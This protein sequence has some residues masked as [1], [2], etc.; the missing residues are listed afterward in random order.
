MND[1]YKE[2]LKQY[3]EKRAIIGSGSYGNVVKTCINDTCYAVK[4]IAFTDIPS[5]AFISEI[6]IMS[7]IDHPNVLKYINYGYSISKGKSFIVLPLADRSLWGVKPEQLKTIL[8]QLS[9]GI[10]HLHTNNIIHGDIK[11]ANC[12]IFSGHEIPIIKVCDYGITTVSYCNNKVYI[13]DGYGMYYYTAPYRPPENILQTS[14][15]DKNSDIWALACTFYEIATGNM[16]ITI[17][18]KDITITDVV[19]SL[20]KIDINDWPDVINLPLY[21]RYKGYFSASNIGKNKLDTIQNEDLKDLLQKMLVYNPNKR[22]NIYQILNHKY[23]SDVVLPDDI[24]T[25]SSDINIQ[26]ISCIDLLNRYIINTAN[27][28]DIKLRSSIFNW[29][30]EVCSARRIPVDQAYDKSLRSLTLFDHYM[31][32]DPDANGKLYAMTSLWCVL[33]RSL[34]SNIYMDIDDDLLGDLSKSFPSIF[35]IDDYFSKEIIIKSILNVLKSV[36]FNMIYTTLRDYMSEHTL[37]PSIVSSVYLVF[38]THKT[39]YEQYK[40]ASN[41]D[42]VWSSGDLHGMDKQELKDFLRG[43]ERIKSEYKPIY[44]RLE[45]ILSSKKDDE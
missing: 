19:N 18:G 38:G 15:V 29:F 7:I 21:D 10:A 16:L 3:G 40:I 28:M 43:L 44:Y 32:N 39:P 22:L 41:I 26:P 23:F 34:A 35:P 9:L 13:G 25:K 36:K 12:L 24:Y 27:N 4:K 20:G 6:S 42:K 14:Y 1:D 30:Y 8:Y 37:T 11:T 45:K 31:Q 17:K 33:T 5:A 2:I